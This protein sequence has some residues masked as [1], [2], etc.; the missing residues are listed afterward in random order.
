MMTTFSFLLT[1]SDPSLDALPRKYLS[2]K[3]KMCK[4]KYGFLFD[5]ASDT[6]AVN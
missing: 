2:F 1:H 4:Y 3:Y 6:A 5:L